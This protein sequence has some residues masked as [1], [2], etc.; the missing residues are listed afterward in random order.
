[1]PSGSNSAPD[2][3]EPVLRDRPVRRVF[4]GCFSK[5]PVL[6]FIRDSRDFAQEKTGLF[7]AVWIE[8]REFGWGNLCS[9][10]VG[11][12]DGGMRGRLS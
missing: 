10:G 6:G 5:V 9:G 11:E 8:D 3:P 4:R 12:A 1:M 2:C 7:G